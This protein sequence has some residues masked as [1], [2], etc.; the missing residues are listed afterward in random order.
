MNR[1]DAKAIA[2]PLAYAIRCGTRGRSCSPRGRGAGRGGAR[3]C[4]PC[5]PGCRP[6]TAAPSC[7]SAR[8][9]SPRRSS[10]PP[11]RGPPF[12]FA[13]AIT[14]V[15]LDLS[16]DK[17]VECG[18]PGR[19]SPPARDD[20]GRAA[21]RG[22]PVTRSARVDATWPSFPRRQRGGG[23][24]GGVGAAHRRVPADRGALGLGPAHDPEQL[25]N[26]NQGP[27]C[28]D[29]SKPICVDTC[30]RVRLQ[31]SCEWARSI[32]HNACNRPSPR[33]TG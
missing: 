10:A 31:V 19:G 3:A 27:T 24:A 18:P 5:A 30:G 28:V 32:N 17:L 23:G 29:P 14:V 25:S 22:L 2:P 20:D 33:P 6:P 1:S 9:P 15:G 21:V 8:S 13:S 16:R 11:W 4:R 12:A 26:P 7:C